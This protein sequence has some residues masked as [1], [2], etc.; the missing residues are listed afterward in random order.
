MSDTKYKKYSAVLVLGLFFVASIASL[1]LCMKGQRM[2]MALC[3]DSTITSPMQGAQNCPMNMEQHL[4]WWKSFFEMSLV[5]QS[6]GTPL[7]FIAFSILFASFFTLNEKQYHHYRYRK[8][9]LRSLYS[10]FD[11]LFS[12]G[13]LHAK[14]YP[15]S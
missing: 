6:E 12:T 3:G 9:R 5:S 1:T 13:I 4:K 7:V 15:A 10:Y 8:R 2:N 14:I 11:R